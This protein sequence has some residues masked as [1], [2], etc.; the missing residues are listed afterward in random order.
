MSPSRQKR[1]SQ[2]SRPAVNRSTCRACRRLFGGSTCD[3]FIT[4]CN[5]AASWRTAALSPG[6]AGSRAFSIGFACAT[7]TRKHTHLHTHTQIQ[8]SFV[9]PI[10]P[11][12]RLDLT[13]RWA[14]APWPPQAQ[15]GSVGSW[16]QTSGLSPGTS[17]LTNSIVSLRIGV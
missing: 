2:V 16:K 9:A 8:Q 7:R 3:S 5:C 12:S 15:P 10:L 17:C 14:S 6:R 1:S 4:R 11:Q 13:R